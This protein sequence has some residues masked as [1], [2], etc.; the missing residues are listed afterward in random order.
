MNG[1]NAGQLRDAEK[2]LIQQVTK[3]DM[4]IVA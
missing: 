2:V 1:S 3:D 4:I